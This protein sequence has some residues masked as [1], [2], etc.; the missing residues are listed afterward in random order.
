MD[1]VTLFVICHA[2][3][4]F[5][6]SVVLIDLSTCEAESF[7]LTVIRAWLKQAVS[8]E[9]HTRIYGNIKSVYVT[10]EYL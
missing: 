7:F 3:F 2:V 10:E 1:I 6:Q 5:L 4:L 8:H 9:H